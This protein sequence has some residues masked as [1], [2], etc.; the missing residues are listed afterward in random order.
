M[1]LIQ[2]EGVQVSIRQIKRWIL[3]ARQDKDNWVKSL[4]ATYA[5]GN[6][7]LLREITSDIDIFQVTGVNILDLRNLAIRLQ[8]EAMKELRELKELKE[9]RS[10]SWQ[11][12]K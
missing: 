5:V 1:F 12:Q 2:P 10:Y 7:D 3:A 9:L 4:H 11:G 6:I 8:D